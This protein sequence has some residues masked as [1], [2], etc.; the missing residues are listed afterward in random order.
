MEGKT[1]CRHSRAGKHVVLYRIAASLSGEFYSDLFLDR[2]RLASGKGRTWKKNGKRSALWC[3]VAWNFKLLL[4]RCTV[5]GRNVPIY[6][7]NFCENGGISD[8]VDA[9]VSVYGNR[10]KQTADLRG[11]SLAEWEK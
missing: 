9:F 7:G 5:C 1:Y 10:P 3:I 6:S 4:W 11:Q 8:P 2:F